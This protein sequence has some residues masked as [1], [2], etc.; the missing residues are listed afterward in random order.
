MTIS[1]PV[2]TPFPKSKGY[3]LPSHLL[4]WV[5]KKMQATYG[6]IQWISQP[7]GRAI[8]QLANGE[9]VAVRICVLHVIRTQN[10]P[11]RIHLSIYMKIVVLSLIATLI[12]HP[13]IGDVAYPNLFRPADLQVFNQVS[14]F[15][16]PVT[17]VCCYHL[18]LALPDQQFM[19][20][21]QVKQGI[22]ADINLMGVE[23]G[24]QHEKEFA[25]S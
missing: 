22:P 2:H 18:S 21:K 6:N 17:G 7:T 8:F 13:D 4:S 10:L 1:G 5:D 12:L 24:I 9:A 19:V 16:H 23:L 20:V 25:C 15:T 14:I 3:S 11:Y